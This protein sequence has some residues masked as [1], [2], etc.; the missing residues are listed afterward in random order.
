MQAA[1][2]SIDKDLTKT[3][4]DSAYME[5]SIYNKM[6]LDRELQN[7]SLQHNRQQS[8]AKRSEEEI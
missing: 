7:E 6:N 4:T 5:V 2:D 3:A 1:Y 8:K